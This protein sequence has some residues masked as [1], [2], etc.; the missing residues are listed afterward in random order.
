MLGL[1]M[2]HFADIQNSTL[3]QY[4]GKTHN[5]YASIVGG[6]GFPALLFYILFILSLALYI[7]RAIKRVEVDSVPWRLGHIWMAILVSYAVYLN[8]A[9]AEFHFV[10]V[11]FA[12]IAISLRNQY[13]EFKLRELQKSKAHLLDEASIV[14][15]TVQS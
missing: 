7:R 9:P 11:W 14:A 6:F 13:D 3:V 8:G 2:G 12:L 15:R 1:G 10:W 4:G 5:N